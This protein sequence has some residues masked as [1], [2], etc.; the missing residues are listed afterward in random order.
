MTLDQIL[1]VAIGTLDS[2]GRRIREFVLFERD[3]L[4]VME[5]AGY[6]IVAE[7]HGYGLTSDQPDET[8]EDTSVFVGINGDADKARPLVAGVL[9]TYGASSACFAIDS[10]HEPVFATEDGYRATG[11]TADLAAAYAPVHG[12]YPG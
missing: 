7:T 2:N 6:T 10:A 4:D 3:I 5:L 9:K 11:R 1:T 8:T 12:G